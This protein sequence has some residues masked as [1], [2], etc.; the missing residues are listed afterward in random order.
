[1]KKAVFYLTFVCWLLSLPSWPQAVA[2]DPVRLSVGARILG[3]GK[4]FIGLSDDVGAIYT[5]PSGLGNLDKWQ[6]S[7]MSGKF[8]EDYNYLNFSGAYP[9]QYGTLGFGYALSSIAGGYA[10][11]I[12]PGTEADPVYDIDTTQPTISYDNNVIVLSYGNK[13]PQ[14]LLSSI[15]ISAGANLKLFSSKMAGDGITNGSASGHDLDL[16]CLFKI[17]PWFSF[18]STMQDILPFSMGGKLSYAS[19]HEEAYPA[20]WK[21]GIALRVLGEK[22][23]LRTYGAHELKFIFDI[24][25]YPTR[26]NFPF[27]YH[28]GIEWFPIKM[29]AVRA[30]ID[31][32]ASG[33]GNGTGLNA[34]SNMTAGVGVNVEG[35]SFDYAYHQYANVPGITNNYFSLSYTPIPKPPKIM[36]PAPA[37]TPT[38]PPVIT[39]QKKPEPAPVIIKKVKPA[40]KKTKTIPQKRRK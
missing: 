18:G 19:G 23:A 22:N 27:T 38:P 33:D 10:T 35:F 8:M 17:N 13:I 26:K 2:P 20:L 30:G 11:K 24:D 40:P 6:V 32:D 36:A 25:S 3:M 21:N 4:A 31:Q 37:P 29:V 39:I 1:M 12:R 28:T 34:I 7:S 16:G 15:E 9:T 5:N 14:S